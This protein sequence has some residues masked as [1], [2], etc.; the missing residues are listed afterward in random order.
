VRVKRRLATAHPLPGALRAPTVPLPQGRVKHLAAS[1]Q[2][3]ARTAGQRCL[4][5]SSMVWLND[6]RSVGAT[7]RVAPD[8]GE[9]SAAM[10]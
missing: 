8:R 10:Y 1:T 9:T 5:R 4:H 3:M 6:T 7:R 2:R